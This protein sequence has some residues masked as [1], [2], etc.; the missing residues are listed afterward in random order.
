[1][2]PCTQVVNCTSTVLAISA[3][4]T[5]LAA[6]TSTVLSF[7]IFLTSSQANQ[8]LSCVVSLVNTEVGPHCMMHPKLALWNRLP[9]HIPECQLEQTDFHSCWKELSCWA[10]CP[11]RARHRQ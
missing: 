6:Q 9:V 1:M 5:V 3:Q 10:G 11:T 2:G 7:D 4:Y 8:A